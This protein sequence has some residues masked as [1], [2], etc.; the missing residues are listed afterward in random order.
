MVGLRFADPAPVE[1]PGGEA[2]RA[3]SGA[4]APA[5]SGTAR[6][7]AV[8]LAEYFDGR[9]RAFELPLA[10]GGSAFEREVWDV[11]TSIP[12]G[13]TT[14]YGAIAE[15]LGGRA[16]ARAVGG[17]VGANPI[18]VVVPCHRVV[19]ADGSLTGYGGGLDRKRALLALEGAL[20]GVLL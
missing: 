15:R 16:T 13:A 18:A 1:R 19:G 5:A 14:T 17:A 4:D 20:P 10:P 8:Q 7:L 3:G 2:S 11:L 12:Y 9:R 6:A